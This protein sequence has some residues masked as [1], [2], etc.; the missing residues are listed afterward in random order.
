MS[1]SLLSFS[2]W[3]LLMWQ[4]LLIGLFVFHISEGRTPHPLHNL[5][6]CPQ[7]LLDFQHS[8][9]PGKTDENTQQDV[10]LLAFMEYCGWL[11][12][13][14]LM[15][16]PWGL[17]QMS[18]WLSLGT[19][20][21]RSKVEPCKIEP[22][23]FP[24]GVVYRWVVVVVK[25]PSFPGLFW[26]CQCWVTMTWCLQNGLGFSPALLSAPGN[27]GSTVWH[28]TG[29][30][31]VSW[32]LLCWSSFLPPLPWH[33]EMGSPCTLSCLLQSRVMRICIFCT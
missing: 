14:R 19:A 6:L 29:L 5:S 26:C 4:L 25:A 11:R 8:L 12:P 28:L 17:I 30:A 20:L 16:L 22:P 32:R 10:H 31:T 1:R 27:V 3:K 33:Q 23:T 13:L 21:V 7:C 9:T 15:K 2:I 24:P 18:V